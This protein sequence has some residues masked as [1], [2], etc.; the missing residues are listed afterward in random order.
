MSDLAEILARKVAEIEALG[1]FAVEYRKPCRWCAE[2]YEAVP[3]SVSGAM[4]HPD[5]PVGRVVCA[6]PRDA[7][8]NPNFVYDRLSEE[9]HG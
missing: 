9:H 1:L 6:Y 8:K 2:G 3:S 4:V 7:F 5:S